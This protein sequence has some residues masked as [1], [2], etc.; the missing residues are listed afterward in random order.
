MRRNI[1]S[2]FIEICAHPEGHRQLE[3][4]QTWRVFETGGRTYFTLFGDTFITYTNNIGSSA[5]WAIL[6]ALW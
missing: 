3:T 6:P 2:K 4:N 5:T 1:L